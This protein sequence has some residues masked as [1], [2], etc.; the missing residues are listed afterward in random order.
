M[1]H[2]P[3]RFVHA[4]DFHLETPPFGVCEV[5]EHLRELFLESVY[6][7]AERVFETV[8]AEEANFL[9]LSGDVLNPQYTGPRGPLFLL[10]QFE[11]LAER[12]IPVYWAGGRVDPP[13][14]WPPSVRLPD[15]VHVFGRGM[16]EEHL[17][18]HE[19]TVI[20]RVLGAG[21]IRG[22]RIRAEDYE[23]DPGGVFTVGVAYGRADVESLKSRAI[24]YWALG[25]RHARRSLFT[26]PYIAHYP[27]TPQGRHPEETGAHGC[28]LV[29]VDAAGR[30]RTTLVPTDVMRWHHER[31]VIDDATGRDDF[32]RLLRERM[33]SLSQ[34]TGETDLIVSWTVAGTGPL[35]SS[36][37][38]G[39]LGVEMLEWLRQEYGQGPP[40]AWSVSLETEPSAVLP[41]SWYE[42]DTIRGDFLRVV[43]HL[44]VN[45]DEPLGLERYLG[46]EQLAGEIGALVGVS[47]RDTRQGVLREA[48]MLGVDLLTGEG[49]DS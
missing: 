38:H 13:E 12:D 15:N 40:A 18:R 19:Q 22:K 34:T 1:S 32:Q 36:L 23:P 10:D 44:Q 14:A 6:W 46:E 2:R 27:G 9:V 39:S 20:A 21:G 17:V 29:Q 7:A 33:H 49:P 24:D 45:D 48:M 43:H 5:P 26:S 16:P 30:A 31:V 37:R 8:L 35:L 3:I 28:T 42:Q 11:R 41:Q 47:D 4:A 25:G